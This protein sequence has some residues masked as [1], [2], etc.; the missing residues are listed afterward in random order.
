M[1]KYL[2]QISCERACSLVVKILVVNDIPVD[3]EAPSDFV[4]LKDLSAQSSKILPGVW[5]A[6]V[7]IRMSVC[8]L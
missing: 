4:N 3:I 5:F 8:A 6:H 7:F 1:H 2:H